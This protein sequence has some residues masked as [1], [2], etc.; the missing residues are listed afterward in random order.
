MLTTKLCFGQIS[1]AVIIRRK[2]WIVSV[3]KIYHSCRKR[4]I[5]QTFHKHVKMTF[6]G[7]IL[8]VWCMKM[9]EKPKPWNNLWRESNKSWKKS[10]KQFASERCSRFNTHCKKSKTMIGSSLNVFLDSLISN[11]LGPIPE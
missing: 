2:Y 3:N 1:A 4:I 7:L 9:T 6:F 5:R 8:S 10:T 11:R